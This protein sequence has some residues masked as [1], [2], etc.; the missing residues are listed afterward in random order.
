[1]TNIIKFPTEFIR[2]EVEVDRAHERWLLF[3]KLEAERKAKEVKHVTMACRNMDFSTHCSYVSVIIYYPQY[4]VAEYHPSI[5][6][7][8]KHG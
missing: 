4:N 1:M 2:A 3:R 6:D 8:G 5:L 7:E